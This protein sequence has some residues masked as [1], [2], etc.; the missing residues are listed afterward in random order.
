M[1]RKTHRGEKAKLKAEIES[2]QASAGVELQ[3]LD[4]GA[5]N[6]QLREK[7]RHQD[8][9]VFTEGCKAPDGEL[10]KIASGLSLALVSEGLTIF[11][12]V[13]KARAEFTQAA[14]GDDDR[15]AAIAELRLEGAQAMLSEHAKLTRSM[16]P[17]ISVMAKLVDTQ[18]KLDADAAVG[19]LTLKAFDGDSFSSTFDAD[20]TMH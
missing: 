16:R 14:T 5:I 2:A 6:L 4:F 15:A 13:A 20:S 12:N 8:R 19:E 7:F 3:S 9:A 17:L 1:A 10:L 11:G 18:S